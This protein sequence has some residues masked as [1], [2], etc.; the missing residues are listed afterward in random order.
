[1]YSDSVTTFSTLKKDIADFTQE[2]DWNKFH[3]PKNLAISV[4]LE[5][6]ELLEIWQ[7]ASYEKE[8]IDSN[9]S[10]RESIENEMADII[11]YLIE[12]ANILDIDISR[13]VYNKLKI[14]E[15]KYP[16]KLC[17]GKS[18]KYTFYQYRK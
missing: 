5:A 14:N 13:A 8:D 10:I 6:S 3:T 11:I 15:E 7:W 12:M 9:K 16:A 18:Y 1:M 2:R 4:L 17:R